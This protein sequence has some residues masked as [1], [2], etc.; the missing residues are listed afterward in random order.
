LGCLQER[1]YKLHNVLDRIHV[2]QDVVVVDQGLDDLAGHVLAQVLVQSAHEFGLAPDDQDLLVLLLQRNREYLHHNLGAVQVHTPV[3]TQQL[4]SEGE[5]VADLVHLVAVAGGDEVKDVE[6][7][8]QVCLEGND[9]LLLLIVV[10]DD[11]GEQVLEF[12]EHVDVHAGDAVSILRE[13][14]ESLDEHVQ[15]GLHVGLRVETLDEV[16]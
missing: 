10:L 15:D 12:V 5:T 13:L 9:F 16:D 11:E 3:Y 8:S 4:L 6:D 7:H 1:L 2:P 14:G